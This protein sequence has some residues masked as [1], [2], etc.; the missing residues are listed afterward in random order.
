MLTGSF[1]LFNIFEICNILEHYVSQLKQMYSMR[2]DL[3]GLA[4]INRLK[5]NSGTDLVKDII[6]FLLEY[7]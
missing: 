6:C 7:F 5:T 3:K 4:S 1:D 2:I